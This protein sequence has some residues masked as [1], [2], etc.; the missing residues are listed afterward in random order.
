MNGAQLLRLSAILMT[1]TPAHL[2]TTRL[3]AI[4]VGPSDNRDRIASEILVG[5]LILPLARF[6]RV[7]GIGIANR[8]VF[9]TI[10]C[11]NRETDLNS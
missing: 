3:L 5:V 9:V 10:Y 4:P 2:P 6:C 1:G 7:N 11:V 8:D